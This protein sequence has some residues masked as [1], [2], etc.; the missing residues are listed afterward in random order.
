VQFSVLAQMQMF[1]LNNTVFTNSVIIL[2]T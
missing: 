1:V 2:V